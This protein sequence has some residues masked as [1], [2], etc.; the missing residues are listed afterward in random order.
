MGLIRKVLGPKSKYEKGIPNAYE[1]RISLAGGDEV[2]TTYLSDTICGLVEHL[3][4]EG[5]DPA[6][7][8]I[9]ERDPEQDV[10]L[11]RAI[12]T[13]CRGEWLARPALCRS[14][15]ARYPGHIAADG[16]TFSDRDKGIA[17]R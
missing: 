16:C 1:A 15:E 12:Y 7:V 10:L 5:V 13:G 9:L 17:G 4:A 2:T 14:F 3:Q 8:E 11:P 6:T